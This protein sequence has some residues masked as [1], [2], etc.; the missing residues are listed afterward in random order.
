MLQRNPEQA[1]EEILFAHKDGH[2]NKRFY[3]HYGLRW[4][5]GKGI[6]F[7]VH[8]FFCNLSMGHKH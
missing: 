6:A 4:L 2:W 5:G 7:H 3:G 1:R 8:A